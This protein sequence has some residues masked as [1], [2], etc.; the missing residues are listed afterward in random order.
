MTQNVAAS[1]IEV[2]QHLYRFELFGLTFNG[3]TLLAS[4][5]AALV[6]IG[7]AF[8][9]RAKIT[10][11]VPGGVQLFF[12]T[13]T[14]AARQ[15]VENLIGLRV[16][17]F[18]VPLALALFLYILIANWI[19]VLPVQIGGHDLLP[20]PASDTNF[21]YALAI[22]VFV[23]YHVAGARRRGAGKHLVQLAKGHVSALAPL[24]IVEELSK[25]ISLSLRLFGN[26]FGGTIMVAL[27]MGMFPPYILWAP[28]VIWK[29][30]DLFVGLIQ[31]FIFALLTILYFSQSMELAEDHH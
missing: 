1:Q 25:P 21:T 15:Q 31:A 14:S 16:A 4:A 12:E 19:A 17:P 8:M 20:P 3:D 11:G 5:V 22:L 28:N 7:L 13:I 29:L 30:F 24:N 6:I 9:L 2:G 27:I 23:W 10:A 18:V 26:V